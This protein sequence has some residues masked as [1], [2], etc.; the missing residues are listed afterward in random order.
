MAWAEALLPCHATSDYC[1]TM[2]MLLKFGTAWLQCLALAALG[3]GTF[4]MCHQWHCHEMTKWSCI[5]AVFDDDS[6]IYLNCRTATN[7][8]CSEF[9]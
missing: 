4:P 2:T 3:D 7:T 5:L 9:T 8:I 6:L 1:P